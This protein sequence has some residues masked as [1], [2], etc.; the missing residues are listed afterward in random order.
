MKARVL[1]AEPVLPPKRVVLDLSEKEAAILFLLFASTSGNARG[2]DGADFIF[3][4]FKFLHH[5]VFS[6]ATTEAVSERFGIRYE[7]GPAVYEVI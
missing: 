6:D 4:A 5:A 2:E 1:V 3:E 7:D